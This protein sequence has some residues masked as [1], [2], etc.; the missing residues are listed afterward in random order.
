MASTHPNLCVNGLAVSV[1]MAFFGIVCFG[2]VVLSVQACG[3]LIAVDSS[4]KLR[5]FA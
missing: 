4:H 3:G 2:C 5:R 1:G